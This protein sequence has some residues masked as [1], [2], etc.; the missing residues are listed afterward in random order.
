VRDEHGSRA[1][2]PLFEELVDRDPHIT[3]SRVRTHVLP[4]EVAAAVLEVA[5]EHLVAFAQVERAGGHVHAGRRIGNEGEVV[6]LGAD[7]GGE[8]RA[9][10]SEQLG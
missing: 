4:C 7:E 9:G 5:R 1:V 6:E 2:G 10:R 8:L 3:R